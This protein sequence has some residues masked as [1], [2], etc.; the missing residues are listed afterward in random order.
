[1]AL[2]YKVDNIFTCIRIGFFFMDHDLIMRNLDRAEEMIE[3]G[4]DYDKRNRFQIYKGFYNLAIR[5][6][7][8]ATNNFLG[9]VS[10]FTC[11]ELMDYTTFIRYTV[12]AAIFTLPRRELEEKVIKAPDVLEV[13]YRAPDVKQYLFSLYQCEYAKFFKSLA[14]VEEVFRK[15]YILNPHY[16]FYVREMRILAYSQLL[17]SYKSLTLSYMAEQFEVTPEFIENELSRFIAD[18]KIFGKIDKAK[19]IIIVNKDAMAKSELFKDVVRQGDLLL[20]RIQNLSRFLDN[21][22]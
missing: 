14:D 12:Y 7:K 10:T 22:L 17:A 19:G 4:A 13:L 16:R 1:M 20:N 9:V 6:F 5:D 3:M 21:K 11:T 18:G 2:G 15:D 8:S